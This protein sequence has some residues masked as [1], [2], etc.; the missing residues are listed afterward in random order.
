MPTANFLST[1]HNIKCLT[2]LVQPAYHRIAHCFKSCS[3]FVAS[4]PAGATRCFAQVH[5]VVAQRYPFYQARIHPSPPS[6]IRQQ[7]LS[8]YLRS[9]QNTSNSGY[10]TD[11]GMYS[12]VRIGLAPTHV[13]RP[14]TTSNI[15]TSPRCHYSVLP[16][17]YARATRIASG[18]IP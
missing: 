3:K 9:I 12:R 13:S 2:E 17:D 11:I 15:F 7:G 14:S 10:F 4:R 16:P 6:Y 8:V 1:V 18:Y 5:L